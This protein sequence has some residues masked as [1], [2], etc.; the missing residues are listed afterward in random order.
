MVILMVYHVFQ[1]LYYLLLGHIIY[2]NKMRPNF[3]LFFLSY[4]LSTGG[5]YAASDG[6][7]G[8]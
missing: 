2:T 3:L 6:G 4:P 8:T 5:P 7:H 1:K